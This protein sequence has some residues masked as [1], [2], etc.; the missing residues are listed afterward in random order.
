MLPDHNALN[1][2]L[3]FPDNLTGKYVHMN[4]LSI[5]SEVIVNSSV[6]MFLSGSV[7][8]SYFGIFGIIAE[9]EISYWKSSWQKAELVLLIGFSMRK[10]GKP[11]YV[12]NW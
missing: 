11:L 7:F 12:V 1:H 8:P 4:W 9:C 2:F 10:Y 5:V 3:A 6:L